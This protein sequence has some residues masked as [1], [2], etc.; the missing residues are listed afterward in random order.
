MHSKSEDENLLYVVNN[1]YV[2]K[3]D[4]NT[5]LIRTKISDGIHIVLTPV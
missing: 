3:C 2:Q 4:R 5:L 1:I